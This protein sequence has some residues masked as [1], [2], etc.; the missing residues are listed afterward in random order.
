[1][2]TYSKTSEKNS[3]GTQAEKWR[4]RAQALAWLLVG[5][6]VIM[7]WAFLLALPIDTEVHLPE[8]PSIYCLD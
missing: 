6:L 4:T 5:L 2:Q 3:P 7:S 8:C 1:M